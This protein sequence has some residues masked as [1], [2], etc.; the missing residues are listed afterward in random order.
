MIDPVS[1]RLDGRVALV[2]GASSGIGAAI[3]EGFAAAGAAVALAARRE[4][5][6]RALAERIVARGGRA[7]AV[8]LDV[9]DTAS[10]THAFDATEAALGR[11]DV[12]V[13]N[14]GIAEP[15]RF[16][17]TSVESLTRVMDTN[18]YGAWS[19]AREGASRLVAA[20]AP[21]SIINI[22]SI[23]GIG[24][25]V[26]YASYAA[27]KGALVQFTRTLALELVEQRIRVNALAPGWFNSE[28][29][30]AYFSSAQGQAHVARMPPRRIGVPAELIGPALLLASE[31]GSYVNGVVL[32]V[33]GGH[34]VAL[35]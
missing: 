15:K 13:N 17:A 30:E 20:R 28:M 22:A 5:R 27:S 29:T 16:L 31:A 34:S 8:R 12:I 25:A 7:L 3:A 19:V 23:L 2:T 26:G 18:F 9:D 21:G 11:V 24:S 1:F 4:E 33:D 35:V 32:P 14:A 10:I 6:V